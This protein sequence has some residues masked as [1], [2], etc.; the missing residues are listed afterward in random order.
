[1]ALAQTS[2]CSALPLPEVDSG[3]IVVDFIAE[4]NGQGAIVGN[5]YEFLNA[6][7]RS[8]GMHLCQSSSFIGVSC[9]VSQNIAQF[10][11]HKPQNGS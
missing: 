6:A 7:K 9:N 2:A 3:K 11:S 8:L 4:N 5:P 10:N 1:M